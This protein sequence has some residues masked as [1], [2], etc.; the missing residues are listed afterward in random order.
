[1]NAKQRAMCA[2]RRIN[3]IEWISFW[4]SEAA[5]ARYGFAHRLVQAYEVWQHLDCH[6][7]YCI[8]SRTFRMSFEDCCRF[9]FFSAGLS[10]G[11]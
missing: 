6:T 3:K 2:E 7:Y 8:P 9:F 5:I 4:H 1:M 10:L 11:H